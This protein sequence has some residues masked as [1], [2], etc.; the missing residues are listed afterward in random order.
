MED[1]DEVVGHSLLRNDDLFSSVDDEIPALIINTLF[2]VPGYLDI[3]QVLQV[4]EVRTH[5]HWHSSNQ[6]TSHI[7]VFYD[8]LDLRLLL[9]ASLLEA[10]V[11]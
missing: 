1:Q 6:D 9:L 10:R 7:V 11:L 2:C 5:H 3:I 4:T 8:S